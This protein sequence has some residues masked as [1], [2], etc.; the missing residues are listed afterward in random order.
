[1]AMT[2]VIESTVR[3]LLPIFS[4]ATD[5]EENRNAL[6]FEDISTSRLLRFELGRPK[7]HVWIIVFQYIS[8]PDIHAILDRGLPNPAFTVAAS[9]P[10]PLRT[11]DDAERLSRVITLYREHYDLL[12]FGDPFLSRFLDA[13][14][15][16][17][18]DISLAKR[19]IRRCL[20]EAVFDLRGDVAKSELALPFGTIVVEQDPG[21]VSRVGNVPPFARLVLNENRK[22]SASEWLKVDTVYFFPGIYMSPRAREDL[23]VTLFDEARQSVQAGNTWELAK[24]D[25]GDLREI[26]LVQR[27]GHFALRPSRDYVIHL[28]RGRSA[29]A[30]MLT[31]LGSNEWVAVYEHQALANDELAVLESQMRE[32]PD[33][34][35]TYKALADYHAAKGDVARSNL[36]LGLGYLRARKVPGI[37]RAKL[38]L[39]AD[40]DP[41]CAGLAAALAELESFGRR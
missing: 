35:E 12:D 19:T 11:E 14:V 41:D 13:L 16:D 34:V 8:R 39:A 3:R 27:A 30:T 23:L 25:D 15:V 21:Y 6:C 18:A 33:Q 1:M 10:L 20:A 38:N 24:G 40:A 5:L 22:A 4:R 7:E 31:Q 2:K 9:G 36:V 29:F 37:A 28:N 26:L 17:Q 32:H